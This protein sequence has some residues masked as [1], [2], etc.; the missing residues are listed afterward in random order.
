MRRPMPANGAAFPPHCSP[1]F[2]MGFL[3]KFPTR[4][5]ELDYA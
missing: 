1:S 2:R 3:L 4:S 5:I